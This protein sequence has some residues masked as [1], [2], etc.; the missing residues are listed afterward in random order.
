MPIKSENAKLMDDSR[1]VSKAMSK[2][3]SSFVN[4]LGEAL[5]HADPNNTQKIK[6]T[7]SEYWDEYLQ[8]Y[9]DTK[10]DGE[11]DE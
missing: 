8:V 11:Y 3:G 2:Y 4:K 10:L 1:N 6:D 5:L 9:K 7:F